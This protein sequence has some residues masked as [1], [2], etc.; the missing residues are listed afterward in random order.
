MSGSGR[1]HNSTVGE[2]REPSTF[3][4][5]LA[6]LQNPNRKLVP[7]IWIL[8]GHDAGVR[9]FCQWARQTQGLTSPETTAVFP[10]CLGSWYF[11][12][13]TFIF[14]TSQNFLQVKVF[15]QLWTVLWVNQLFKVM[16]WSSAV[17]LEALRRPSKMN[18]SLVGPLEGGT[19][20]DRPSKVIR[21]TNFRR[22]RRFDASSFFGWRSFTTEVVCWCTD[23]QIAT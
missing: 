16:R 11:L 4:A 14:I 15:S 12:W 17:E 8:Q 23:T 3:Q 7:T 1:S 10:S 19:R 6:T 20:V 18:W 13:Q 22:N 2:L 21:A 5:H 9:S